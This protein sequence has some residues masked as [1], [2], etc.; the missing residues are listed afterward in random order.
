MLLAVL[1]HNRK[2]EEMNSDLMKLDELFNEWYGQKTFEFRNANV[3]EA[4]GIKDKFIPYKDENGDQVYDDE[5]NKVVIVDKAVDQVTR[6]LTSYRYEQ[7]LGNTKNLIHRN[8]YGLTTV[9]TLGHTVNDVRGTF[10]QLGSDHEVRS[11]NIKVTM[12]QMARK[13]KHAR[14]T[15]KKAELRVDTSVEQF[16][17]PLN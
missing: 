4:L 11:D 17:D 16:K 1:N 9:W 13:N 7:N 15:Q 12:K 5:G 3:R 6:L 8:G 10:G 14:P 2:E